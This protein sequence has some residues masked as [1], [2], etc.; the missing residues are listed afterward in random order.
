MVNDIEK[1][2]VHIAKL[3]QE[4]Q[5]YKGI[6]MQEEIA[7]RAFHVVAHKMREDKELAERPE[8]PDGVE[9]TED[10]AATTGPHGS[11]PSLSKAMATTK[12]PGRDLASVEA[13]KLVDQLLLLQNVRVDKYERQLTEAGL[14]PLAGEAVRFAKNSRAK[15]LQEEFVQELALAQQE[16]KGL[17][18]HLKEV[19][20]EVRVAKSAAG[21]LV[22]PEELETLATRPRAFKKNQTRITF[23]STTGAGGEAAPV[24][25]PGGGDPMW[26][27]F[28]RQCEDEDEVN[29]PTPRIIKPELAKQHLLGAMRNKC[30][31][32]LDPK[33]GG[34]GKVGEDREGAGTTEGSP[35]PR[36]TTATTTMDD[37]TSTSTTSSAATT[38]STPHL[39][40]PHKKTP[41]RSSISDHLYHCLLTIYADRQV[42]MLIMHGILMSIERHRTDDPVMDLM[43]KALGGSLEEP[44]VWALVEFERLVMRNV[45]KHTDFVAITERL[46]PEM[47]QS[48]REAILDEFDDMYAGFNL[49]DSVLCYFASKLLVKGEARYI[50][51]LDILFLEDTMGRRLMGRADV[52]RV[53]AKHLYDVPREVVI[54]VHTL[55]AQSWGH[56]DIPIETLALAITALEMGTITMA[57]RV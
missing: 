30:K 56:A 55:L 53:T 13:S 8:G 18:D 15:V 11:P 19:R 26:S 9:S 46:Y 7:R 1:Y 21:L 44:V 52:L 25:G 14:K 22:R 43:A 17:K 23:K 51:W 10:A 12:A 39:H 2:R 24:L 57:R 28:I 50:R 31:R 37:P 5:K 29:P 20:L 33:L 3:E 34:L 36:M 49:A 6:S 27:D 4:L 42:S 32:D 45:D 35:V 16:I 41:I 38:T 54:Q 47:H 40:T 48:Q